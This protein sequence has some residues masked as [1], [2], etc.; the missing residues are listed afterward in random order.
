VKDALQEGEANRAAERLGL[1]TGGLALLA[2]GPEAVVAPALGAL[3]GELARHYELIPEGRHEFLWVTEF[4]LVEWG[5]EDNRWFACNHPFTAPDPRDLDLLE[6]DP[7]RV[8]SRGY[9]VVM[10]GI[11]L[12]GGSIRIHD[13][14]LQARVFELLGIGR[15]EAQQ[16]FGF[17]LDA[18]RFGAPPHGGIALGLD[19]LIM[20]MT[21][22]PS[23]RDVIAFPKTTSAL[24]LMT[25]APAPVTAEQLAGLGLGAD[26]DD[27]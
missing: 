14:E 24:C 25:G 10:D 17:L 16:R 26:Q 11:E 5:A 9:D 12:G 4:P 2:A 20:L 27:G 23:I 8:R 7:G 13:A 6:S 15:E 22:A 1:T 19:R 3:R 21:G 18:L